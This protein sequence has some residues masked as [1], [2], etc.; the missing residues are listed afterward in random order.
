MKYL[1]AILVFVLALMLQLWFA[2]A[3]MHGDFV[4]ATLITFAFLFDLWELAA[5][6]LLGIL[7]LNL[8]FYS[9]TTMLLFALV[10]LAVCFLRRRFSLDPWLGTAAGIVVGTLFFYGLTAPTAVLHAAEFFLLD[11]LAC[12]FFGELILCG[13]EG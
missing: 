6:I 12:V 2:P 5:F 13:M 11:I 1:S 7:L 8:F 9:V 10:P 4:L 3:G